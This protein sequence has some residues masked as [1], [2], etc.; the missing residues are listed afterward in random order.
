MEMF[1]CYL[2]W[3]V[4]LLFLSHAFPKVYVSWGWHGG[5]YLTNEEAT[6]SALDA[7]F[8]YLSAN[9][10]VKAVLELEPYTI[11]RMLNGE[12]F[13]LEKRG[14]EEKQIRNWERGGVGEW[15]FSF[16]KEYAHKGSVGV[17]LT[18]EEG[19]YVHLI[20]PKP[21][22]NL[23]GKTLIFSGWIR[24]H[25]GEGA[26]L[27]IDAWDASS[28]IPHS[29]HLS[30]RVPP[31]GNWHYVEIEFPVP[32]NAVTIF[33]QAKLDSPGYADF[34]DLSLRI[35]ETGE[36]L[37]L[38]GDL[39]D[40]FLPSLEDKARLKKLKELVKGGQ[41]EIVGGAY[42]QPIMY[43]I[44]EEAVV[45]QFLLGCKAV[46]EALDIP[47]KI[48]AAQEPGMI[49]QLPQILK[50]F[51]FDAILYR[52]SWGAFGFV[53]SF[54]GEVVNWIG[55]D[56][57][58]FTAIPQ[59]QPL[60]SGWGTPSFP[61]ASL[62]EECKRRGIENPLFVSFGDFIASWVDSSA[63]PI[64]T[65]KLE[66]GYANLCQRLPAEN[67]RGKRL[68]LSA[69]VRA[70]K[71]NAHLYIDAHN[72][73]GVARGGTQT[74]DCPLDDKWHLL[75][76]PF[77]VPDDAVFIF[78]Q[79]RVISYE[80]GEADFDAL[81]L[82][83]EEGKELLSWG[84]L[85]VDSLPPEWGVGKS[86]RVE[87]SCEIV[88]GEAMEGER[89]AR[90]KMRIQPPPYEAEVTTIKGYLEA[91]SSPTRDW[92]DAYKGFEHRF[93]FGL[94]AGRPQK[95]DRMAEET[96]LKTERLLS[97]IYGE[98]KKRPPKELLG[99][100]EDAWRL[101]LI[102]HHH[103]AWVCA[104]VIFGIWSKGF[105]SYAELTYTA[106]REAR[107]ICQSLVERFTKGDWQSFNLVNLSTKEWEGIAD[108]QLSLPQG[109]VKNPSFESKGRKLP[110]H[111]EVLSRHPDGSVKELK[112][113]IL[114][115]LPPMGYISLH[116]REGTSPQI[117]RKASVIIEGDKAVLENDF[118]R[119][120]I[121][122]EG[123]MAYSPSAEQLLRQ[124]AYIIA[125]FSSG[126]QR[127]EIEEIKAYNEGPLAIGEAKG[128]VGNL[129]FQLRLT[130]SPFSPLLRLS[131]NFNF[132]EESVIG[133]V[134]EFPPMPNV[135]DWA[136][137]DLKLRL[138]LPLNF[139]QPTFFSHGAFEL[140]EPYDEFFPILRYGGVEG[141]GRGLV[142][143]TDRTTSGI[144]DREGKTLSVVLAYG[145]NF[146][147]APA[148]FAPLTGEENY[149]LALYFYKGD[150]ETAR[151]AR[152]GEEITGPVIVL[153]RGESLKK[154]AFSLLRINPQ[155][156]VE[157][158]ALYPVED[159]FILRLWRPYEGEKKI[160]IAFPQGREIWLTDMRGN[161]QK[162][163]GDDGKASFSI[164]HNEV[165]TLFVKR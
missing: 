76:L 160:S 73:Q 95:A 81:S 143:Y 28:F 71:G 21:A 48:Y 47:V 65:G 112:A 22:D 156:A 92:F 149:E 133:A 138:V 114:A 132:G 72:A 153:P 19:T 97:L 85:E 100:L 118:L 18:L 32:H 145:G 136:R 62:V 129:P 162:R 27:Y 131:L 99:E 33:P 116:L 82:K 34:D 61:T 51:G 157:L 40:V 23:R 49:G 46:E 55:P 9:P 144:F 142:I 43:T 123:L 14:R 58:R 68:E 86:E 38:N 122:K 103:D 147:Y 53:P 60:R 91:I 25:K 77:T 26:H 154:D 70:R 11:E 137:D 111:I 159:G 12:R 10:R 45:R 113:Q 148:N 54:D 8:K 109:L 24:A 30:Q 79:G 93:P 155:D 152:Y 15:K 66:G 115:K 39:E 158:S 16:A 56:G 163:I 130:L 13:P 29:S 50:K 119:V 117:E 98:Q 134:G 146:I 36:E 20:Q 141:D 31:D 161:P 107:A 101:L 89:F 6:H 74:A 106:S 2:S 128:K 78:P 75:K 64:L 84:S 41:I 3:G 42:T 67:L 120:V 165:I 96:I 69:W 127:G 102:G 57:T 17:R 150:R 135:P 94:L 63:S 44:G 87:V 140:R 4:F 126:D 105:K 104:P 7:L 151:I 1:K 110:S 37:L 88:K 164:K 52:T 59:P 139:E 124:P 83:D 108:V 121:S 125:H 5:Y 80:E 35:K 90:L